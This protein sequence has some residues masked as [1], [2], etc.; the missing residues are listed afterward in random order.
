MAKEHHQ[1]LGDVH[2]HSRH[3]SFLLVAVVFSTMICLDRCDVAQS[4]QVSSCS[5]CRCGRERRRTEWLQDVASHSI[6]TRAGSRFVDSARGVKPEIHRSQRLKL[7]GDL[8][9]SERSHGRGFGPPRIVLYPGS[10]GCGG[11]A[12]HHWEFP[13][14]RGAVVFLQ[15]GKHQWAFHNC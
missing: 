12:H 2:D 9:R 1:A 13:P 7:E 4:K 5:R 10:S 15:P 3:V 11:F 6:H 14:G 8:R